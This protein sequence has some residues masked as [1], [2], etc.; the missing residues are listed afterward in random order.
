MD[1]FKVAV[2]ASLDAGKPLD[3]QD[4]LLASILKAARRKFAHLPPDQLLDVAWRTARDG[5]VP[6]GV[7]KD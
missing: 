2:V 5:A 4:A 3:L 6:N 7:V 1:D